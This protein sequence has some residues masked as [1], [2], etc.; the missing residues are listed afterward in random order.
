MHCWIWGANMSFADTCGAAVVERCYSRYHLYQRN[1]CIPFTLLFAFRTARK[2]LCA[3]VQQWTACSS[4]PLGATIFQRVRLCSLVLQWCHTYWTT[5][6]NT[7]NGCRGC[8]SCP[9]FRT[10]VVCFVVRPLAIVIIFWF[11]CLYNLCG[12]TTSTYRIIIFRLERFW[13]IF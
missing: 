10:D 3:S 4:L 11:P 1:T 7:A 5:W 8:R 9:G 2:G 13:I 12:K 6:E